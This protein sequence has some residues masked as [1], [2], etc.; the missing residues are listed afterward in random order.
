VRVARPDEIAA[1]ID[2]VGERAVSAGDLAAALAC[3][4]VL[5]LDEGDQM[6]GAVV[7]GP[8]AA[9]RLRL[10][11]VHPSI[12]AAGIAERM[13]QAAVVLCEQSLAAPVRSR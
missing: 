4:H 3:G 11:V 6:I 8:A 12:I 2:L 13:Q 1:V 5:V 10:L 9:P 7:V